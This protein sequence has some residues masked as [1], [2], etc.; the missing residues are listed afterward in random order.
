MSY[1]TDIFRRTMPIG[2][3]RWAAMA[4][5]S[6]MRTF[7]VGIGVRSNRE[8][9]QPCE[10]KLTIHLLGFAFSCG[11]ELTR[12]ALMALLGIDDD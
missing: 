8:N 12:R 7:G 10:Y 1:Y 5:L 3:T 9:G 6:R 4:Q 2:A 11:I